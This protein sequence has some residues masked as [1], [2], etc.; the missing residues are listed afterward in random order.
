MFK[1]IAEFY[2][3]QDSGRRYLPG[4]TFPRQGL[5]VT[6]DRL[7]MLASGNNRCGYPLI[8]KVEDETPAESETTKPTRKR[9]KKD[10]D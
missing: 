3:L 7:E 5:T 6:A 10:A 8:A 4:D 9:A 1:V 2:D